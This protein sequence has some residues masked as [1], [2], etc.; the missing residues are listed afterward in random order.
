[1]VNSK[2][3]TL[4]YA[5]ILLSAGC[6]LFAFF[7]RN[8]KVAQ[9]VPPLPATSNST[10]SNDAGKPA[11]PFVATSVIPANNSTI[12]PVSKSVSTAKETL[13]SDVIAWITGFI[14]KFAFKVASIIV[15]ISGKFLNWAFSVP[16]FKGIPAVDIAWK[17]LR[18][19]CNMF[20]IVILMVSAIATILRIDKYKI[21]NIL[22][23]LLIAII[24]INFSK[25]ITYVVVDFTQVLSRSFLSVAGATETSPGTMEIS[26]QLA[27]NMGMAA[28][29]KSPVF[30][31]GDLN[32]FKFT[33][34]SEMLWSTLLATAVML[35]A[36][37]AFAVGAI[38]L[39]VRL[40]MIWLLIA[41]S[42]VAW[43]FSAVP[44]LR[45]HFKK[46]WKKLLNYALFAPAYAFFIAFAMLLVKGGGYTPM[47]GNLLGASGGITAFF[48]SPAYLLNY[49]IT[50]VILWYA[51][52]RA[53]G[54]DSY[55]GGKI[56]NGAVDKGQA[57]LRGMVP[58]RR[59]TMAIM[60]EH[61]RRVKEKEELKQGDAERRARTLYKYKDIG[62]KNT[63][64]AAGDAVR[65]VARDHLGLNFIDETGYSGKVLK[66]HDYSNIIKNEINQKRLETA[67]KLKDSPPSKEQVADILSGVKKAGE[68]V[69]QAYAQY[70]SENVH[71][72]GKNALEQYKQAF[73]ALSGNPQLQAGF[74]SKMKGSRIDLVIK[75][76]NPKLND[77]ELKEK[78]KEVVKGMSAEKIASQRDE[79]W[80]N[81]KYGF[82]DA[83]TESAK[84]TAAVSRM[85]G[86][87]AN[88]VDA[89]EK[90]QSAKKAKETI[91]KEKSA[92]RNR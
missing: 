19:L 76:E 52:G 66:K 64:V 67:K 22:K 85:K 72:F 37:V 40:V 33:G 41:V 13:A 20:F 60:A 30:W 4:R 21:G 77:D 5:L 63:M 25:T 92:K 61:K 74:K 6:L 58:Y 86:L 69:R 38:M 16:S 1:M 36:G 80:K 55:L 18:D 43:G 84:I 10:I 48:R 70:L 7:T 91:K 46:W 34:S 68:G 51:I 14:M 78:M 87:S 42:S 89:I 9:A 3:K 15:A 27:N 62:H 88:K 71:M 79:V 50:I 24:A 11:S 8:V 32:G 82:V 59:T 23:P 26:E 2:T 56:L 17:V 75:A 45:S 29:F 83:L 35:V 54:I 90:S 65:A 49:I 81:N 47:Q 73:S 44:G 39:I 53:K 57:F 12:A 31:G 28:I